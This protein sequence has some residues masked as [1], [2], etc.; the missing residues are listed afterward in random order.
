MY[1]VGKPGS[2]KT[3]LWLSFFL[4]KKPKYYRKFFDRA[5]LVSSSM[6][7]LPSK[8]T[9]NKRTGLPKNQMFRELNDVIIEQIISQLRSGENGNNLLILDD[10]IKDIKSSNSLSKVF[11]N[12]RHITHDKEKEGSS[13]L[14]IMVISQVYNLLPLQFRKNMDHIILFKTENKQ[15]LKFIMDELLFDLSPEEAKRIMNKAWRKKFGFLLI[16]AGQP[17]ENKYF[18]KFDPIKINLNESNDDEEYESE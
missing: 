14:S 10:V 16:K 17:T 8:I 2:G 4:S 1:V 18:D 5:Y 12:R 3:N 11:L 6:D 9:D 13:G 7:T 15:E